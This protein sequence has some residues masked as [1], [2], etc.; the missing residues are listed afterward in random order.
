MLSKLTLKRAGPSSRAPEMIMESILA[1]SKLPRN[2]RAPKL[3]V[4]L[5][6]GNA[7]VSNAAYAVSQELTKNT[8]NEDAILVFNV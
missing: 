6:F 3:A 1:G 5:P 8:V 7:A 4:L 2:A